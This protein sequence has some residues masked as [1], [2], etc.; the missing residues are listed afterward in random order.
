MLGCAS[1]EDSSGSQVKGRLR[2]GGQTGDCGEEAS[3]VTQRRDR[4][5]KEWG[6]TGRP[7]WREGQEGEVPE[8]A[9]RLAM[10]GEGEEGGAT[11]W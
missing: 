3:A 4:E 10:W 11:G 6:Q 7:S 9:D 1:Y 2:E 5:P 8:R